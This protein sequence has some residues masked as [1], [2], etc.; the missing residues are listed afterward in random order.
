[1]LPE[2]YKDTFD[3]FVALAPIVRLDNNKNALMTIASQ[4]WKLLA[5]LVQDLHL[6]NLLP[7]TG[8]SKVLGE[9]CKVLPS[10][11]SA[12]NE[13]FAP[14]HKD[15][16]NNSR[17]GDKFAHDPSGAGWRN[18]IHYAQIIKSKQF[19]RYDFGESANLEK[20]GQ[21]SP[22][23]YDLSKIE[24]PIGI[25]HGSLDA[26]SDTTDDKWLLSSESGLPLKNVVF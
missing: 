7:R 25:F 11:C 4:E 19:Q 6:Y 14:W 1:M 21:N 10:I 12:M 9:F 8:A 16:D 26:L 22:P 5:S 24:V 15:I 23:L 3:L 18:L 2:W 13:G 20:Y 17:A